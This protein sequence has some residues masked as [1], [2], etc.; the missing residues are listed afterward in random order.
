MLGEQYLIYVNRSSDI[1]LICPQ[2]DATNWA[3]VLCYRRIHKTR[4]KH[5][6]VYAGSLCAL[7][8]RMINNIFSMIQCLKPRWIFVTDGTNLAWTPLKAI[9]I[10]ECLQDIIYKWSTFPGTNQ[11]KLLIS[12]TVPESVVQEIK[13]ILQNLSSHGEYFDCPF[14]SSTSASGL[15]MNKRLDV[16]GIW[17]YIWM[18]RIP[19]TEHM[20]N[21][22]T[23]KKIIAKLRENS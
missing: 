18:L 15:Q 8:I 6:R 5:I 1:G 10:L 14:I 7:T 13:Q 16:T 22:R 12:V 21:V 19:L 9:H 20:I 2:C 3:Y 4:E 11:R 17:F 23:V